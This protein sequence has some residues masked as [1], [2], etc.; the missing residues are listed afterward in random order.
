MDLKI[1]I[2]SVIILT[3]L[4]FLMYVLIKYTDKPIINVLVFLPTHGIYHHLIF[5]QHTEA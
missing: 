4:K 3:L 2:L 1:H 5:H